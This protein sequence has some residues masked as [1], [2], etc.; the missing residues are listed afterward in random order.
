MKT[1]NLKEMFIVR[2]ADDFRI[3]CRTKGDA[4]RAKIAIT[5]W[6]S[7]RLKLEVSEAKTRIVNVKRRYSQFLGFKIRVHRKGQKQVVKS[8]MCDKALR[9]QNQS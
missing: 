1:T 5:Q 6:L 9:N 8:H 2:Y 7:D 4:E 3:F